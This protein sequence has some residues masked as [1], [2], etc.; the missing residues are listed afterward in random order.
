M[1]HWNNFYNFKTCSF[2]NSK[3]GILK[4]HRT[5]VNPHKWNTIFTKSTTSKVE[6]KLRGEIYVS[7]WILRSRTKMV[8]VRL[9]FFKNKYMFLLFFKFGG[10]PSCSPIALHQHQPLYGRWKILHCACRRDGSRLACPEIPLHASQSYHYYSPPPQR[11]S[12]MHQPHFQLV[13]FAVH[14]LMLSNRPCSE[15]LGSPSLPW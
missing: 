1:V 9:R 6:L 14:L 13:F 2:Q 5:V 7:H 12:S 4:L 8:Y 3:C 15:T 10:H 11:S